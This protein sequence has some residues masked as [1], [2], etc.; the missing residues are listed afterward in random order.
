[1]E[2]V[3]AVDLLSLMMSE[4]TVP[5][6]SVLPIV[7][8]VCVVFMRKYAI[9]RKYAVMSGLRTLIIMCVIFGLFIC[10]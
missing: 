5:S 1:M 4:M 9:M 2:A 8:D 7:I 3:D 10:S 6:G